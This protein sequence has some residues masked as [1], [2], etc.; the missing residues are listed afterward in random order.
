MNRWV[1]YLL[2]GLVIGV[3]MVPPAQLVSS[4]AFPDPAMAYGFSRGVELQ[5]PVR[6]GS[7]RTKAEG[8]RT[9]WLTGT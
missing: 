7:N 4:S 9:G 3:V 6:S 1:R 8:P 5:P 2:L